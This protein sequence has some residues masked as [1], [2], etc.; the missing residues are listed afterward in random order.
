MKAGWALEVKSYFCSKFIRYALVR[1][2]RITD[3][4]RVLLGEERH[5][6]SHFFLIFSDDRL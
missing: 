3:D 6:D 5:S 1:S 4:S 2:L